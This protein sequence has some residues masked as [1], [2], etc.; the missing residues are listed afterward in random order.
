[1]AAAAFRTIPAITTVQIGVAHPLAEPHHRRLQV[2]CWVLLV[3]DGTS[4]VQVQS[5]LAEIATDNAAAERLGLT[6]P[7]G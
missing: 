1:L 5:H 6:P 2:G 4:L 7:L 3:Q